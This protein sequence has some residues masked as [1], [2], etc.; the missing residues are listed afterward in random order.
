MPTE[1]RSTAGPDGESILIAV[2]SCDKNEHQAQAIRATWL[3]ELPANCRVVFVYARPGEPE[4]L[5]G[6]RLY[7]DC[8][9][10]YE[11][12]PQ[13][14]H[15]LFAYCARN[16]TF[17]YLLKVDDDSYVDIG[18]FLV[19]DKSR[20]DYIGAFQG[21]GDVQA[22]R[23]WHY[24][25][26]TDKS[27]EVPYEGPFVCEWARGGGYL[28]SRRAVEILADKTAATYSDHLFEDKM[29]GE[30]LTPDERIRTVRARYVEMGILNPMP[31]YNMRYV[32]DLVTRRRR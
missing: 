9:E 6:D 2:I 5:V 1:E 24:G 25:K 32:Y 3:Q 29:V 23:T 14:M 19:F 8:Q 30:A 28:L 27:Y 7:V 20:G 22:T 15:R 4:E 11:K 10:A 31:H 17:D 16:L 13:K 21:M 18:R 26:C 12:L